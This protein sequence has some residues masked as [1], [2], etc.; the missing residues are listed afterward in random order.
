[1]TESLEVALVVSTPP[2]LVAVGSLVVAIRNQRVSGKKLDHITVLTNST[3]TA[4]NNRIDQLEGQ[5]EKLLMERH[6]KKPV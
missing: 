4:A 3:L 1:M 5:V 6:E 2:M